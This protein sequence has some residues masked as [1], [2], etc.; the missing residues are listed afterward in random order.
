M[1]V[2]RKAISRVPEIILLAGLVMET[3]EIV[4]DTMAFSL[5]GMRPAV[6]YANAPTGP[7]NVSLQK[8]SSLH[9]T[10]NY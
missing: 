5:G 3:A 10:S 8:V 7:S 2:K 4:C 1:Y 6:Q 9:S